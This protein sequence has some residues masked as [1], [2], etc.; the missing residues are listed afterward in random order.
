MNKFKVGQVWV[1]R[2]GRN[3]TILTTKAK[4]RYR[5]VA[6]AECDGCHEILSYFEDGR[7]SS[8]SEGSSK[9]LVRQ[10]RQPQEW[11]VNVYPNG[12]ALVHESRERADAGGSKTRAECVRVREVIE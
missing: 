11:W 9:D 12:T 5:V 2:D 8:G 4:G 3:A 10:H 1:T 7:Y 6:I